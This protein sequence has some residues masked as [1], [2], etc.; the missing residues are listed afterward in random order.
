MGLQALLCCFLLNRLAE[1]ARPQSQGNEIQAANLHRLLLQ[2]KGFRYDKFL[3]RSRTTRPTV[4]STGDTVSVVP[5][6]SDERG[7]LRPQSLT[8]MDE[9]KECLQRFHIPVRDRLAGVF[10]AHTYK[11]K[12]RRPQ[13]WYGGQVVPLSRPRSLAACLIYK[14]GSTRCSLHSSDAASP[15]CRCGSNGSSSSLQLAIVIPSSSSSSSSSPPPPP[16]HHQ[17]RYYPHYHHRRRYHHHHHHHLHHHHYH[18]IIITILTITANIT[19]S[20]SSS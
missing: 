11:A 17:P 1:G 19:V 10:A 9:A 16:V 2:K 5:A 4:A 3:R 13:R 6:F 18:S 14:S 20:P 12:I 15:P 7:I 8:P